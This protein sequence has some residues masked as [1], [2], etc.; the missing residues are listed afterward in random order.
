MTKNDSRGTCRKHFCA[1]E[2]IITVMNTVKKIYI[3]INV[4]VTE[5]NF[6]QVH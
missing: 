6:K 1:M 5:A 2:K 4:H 3:K